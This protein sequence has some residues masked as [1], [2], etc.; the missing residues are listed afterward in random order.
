MPLWQRSYPS[1]EQSPSSLSTKYTRTR[2][3]TAYAN[4][5]WL[6]PDNLHLTSPPYP[7]RSPTTM[8]QDNL[9][10]PSSSHSFHLSQ[11]DYSPLL[12]QKTA[13]ESTQSKKSWTWGK[14]GDRPSTVSTRRSQRSLLLDFL[15]GSKGSQR[16]P[17]LNPL[18]LLPQVPNSPPK[19]P[20]SLSSSSQM[21][22]RI[23][24]PT[25]PPTRNMLS[26]SRT[27]T[28]FDT[29]QTDSPDMPPGPHPTVT[30]PRLLSPSPQCSPSPLNPHLELPLPTYDE[31]RQQLETLRKSDVSPPAITLLTGSTAAHLAQ[32]CE[33]EE[34]QPGGSKGKEKDEEEKLFK[35]ITGP[36][37]GDP[38][39]G[40]YT[41]PIARNP[42]RWSLPEAPN[43]F[44]PDD[45]LPNPIGA[46]GDDA[47]W[48]RCKPDLIQKPLPFKGEAND[49][50][51]FIT[52]CKIY[53]Q[54]HSTYM[55]PD[56]YRIAFVS[57]YFKELAEEWWILKLAHL[58]SY[59]FTQAIHEKFKDPAIEDKQKANMYALQMIGS[60]TASEYF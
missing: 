26:G 21:M 30:S 55:W 37:K 9:A 27:T 33:H 43:K 25:P 3:G 20:E 5:S 32:E 7:S 8:L 46:M 2:L 10:E 35:Y 39:P 48:L 31:L 14:M 15:K 34:P 22:K 54:V 17:P 4:S 60:M 41:D 29:M 59:S 16:S 6:L 42:E 56:P 44:D 18:N 49:I 58:R 13:P 28:S 23:T 45:E 1:L 53:F 36:L 50:D 47:L 40:C 51:Q 12:S 38:P 52:N 24:V 57:S 19:D 11:Q